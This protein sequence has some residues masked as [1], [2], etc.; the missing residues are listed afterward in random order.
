MSDRPRTRGDVRRLIHDATQAA[1]TLTKHGH[2]EYARLLTELA[3]IA[4]HRLDPQHE[5]APDAYH[6]GDDIVG[7][8][9]DGR[10]A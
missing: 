10:A 7:D 3:D 1:A 5:P 4:R 2:R 9:F 8:L 6:G